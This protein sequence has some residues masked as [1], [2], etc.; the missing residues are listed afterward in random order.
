LRKTIESGSVTDIDPKYFEMKKQVGEIL[1]EVLL[2][3][4]EKEL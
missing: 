3:K 2:K 1:A 4:E